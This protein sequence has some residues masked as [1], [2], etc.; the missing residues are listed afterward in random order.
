MPRTLLTAE[1]IRDEVSTRLATLPEVREDEATIVIPLAQW[2]E[3][4]EFG[5]N[6]HMSFFGGDA[7]AYMPAIQRVVADAQAAYQLAPAP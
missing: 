2:N 3:P 7:M 6:W 1:Q 5:C 4:D